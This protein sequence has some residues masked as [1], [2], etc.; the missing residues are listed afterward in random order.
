MKFRFL[1]QTFCILFFASQAIYARGPL[2]EFS[3]KHPELKHASSI[4]RSQ[5]IVIDHYEA[6]KRPFI[7]AYQAFKDASSLAQIRHK[8]RLPVTIAVDADE[9]VTQSYANYLSALKQYKSSYQ[10]ALSSL[11]SITKNNPIEYRTQIIHTLNTL[12]AHTTPLSN[13]AS[14]FKKAEAQALRSMPGMLS[15]ARRTLFQTANNKLRE[16][17]D[18]SL[19]YYQAAQ[20]NYRLMHNRFNQTIDRIA[21]IA[22]AQYRTKKEI[23]DEIRSALSTIDSFMSVHPNLAGQA[24]SKAI[25]QL[26]PSAYAQ[27]TQALQHLRSIAKK[28]THLQTEVQS[29]EQTII[30]KICSGV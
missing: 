4:S 19:S 20:Q 28:R 16:L 22:V 8:K 7:T 2:F 13:A 15:Q 25:K 6:S 14:L 27:A 21:H 26:S 17:T 10:T 3:L 29:K 30:S 23:T 9:Q 5:Q 24:A 18:P 1:Q 11:V 12:Q